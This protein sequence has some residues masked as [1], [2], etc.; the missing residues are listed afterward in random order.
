MRDISK[1]EVKKI[2]GELYS[3]LHYYDTFNLN[4]VSRTW[5][6]KYCPEDPAN[7]NAIII[8]DR[9]AV[10]IND[11]ELCSYSYKTEAK[12]A[13]NLIADLEFL[14]LTQDIKEEAAKVNKNQLLL[15]F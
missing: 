1:L 8:E 11:K 3:G 12:T 9:Y 5:R 13:K 14:L 2:P 7:N 4:G 15:P 10:F 6:R